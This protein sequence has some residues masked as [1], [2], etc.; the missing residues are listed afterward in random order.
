[1][2]L[3]FA[4]FDKRPFARGT[5]GL[6]LL[7][8]FAFALRLAVAVWWQ[9]G[10]PLDQPFRFSDSESYWVLGQAIARGEPYEYESPHARIFRT[11]GYP[12]LLAGLF[13]CCG[14]NVSVVV[15]RALGAFMGTLVV[16]EIFWLTSLL[17]N[18]TAAVVA[19]LLAACYPGVVGA[20]ILV[21]SESLFCPLLLLQLI[22]FTYAWCAK[23]A[24]RQAVFGVGFG[25]IA[26]LAVLVRPSWLLFTPAVV[27]L[28][29]VSPTARSRSLTIGLG[30]IIGL[31]AAMMPWWIR[32]YQV[33][34]RFVPTTLQVGA[35]LY[36]GWN[37][38][39]TGASDMDFVASFEQKVRAESKGTKAF[40]SDNL[41]CQLNRRF[42]QEACRWAVQH[43]RRVLVLAGIKW[44]RMWHPVPNADEFQ[45]FWMKVAMAVTYV[46]LMILA[47]IGILRWGA[48]SWPLAMCWLPA[49]YVTLL[50][51]VFVG[52]IRYRQPALLPLMVLA[53]GVI[54]MLIPACQKQFV[55]RRAEAPP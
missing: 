3:Q 42:R 34:N 31:C 33:V 14:E 50:H 4:G 12:L 24:G 10:L 54:T 52:S 43:P 37:P 1:M 55:L 9:A 5:L 23:S 13:S 36:D 40:E 45:S 25:V 29:V 6:A 18:R 41:E 8:G 15:A 44:W 7:L 20:S 39:A 22:V 2:P 16:G 49:A 47:V 53:A 51:M 46:P 17:F 11:P 28:T 32:N 48:R 19:A 27:L 26:G 21:L 30:A 35:S 38:K